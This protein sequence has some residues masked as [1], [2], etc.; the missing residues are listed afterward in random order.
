MFSNLLHDTFN[1]FRSSITVAEEL[2]QQH[3]STLESLVKI[4]NG[5]E[6]TSEIIKAELN[7]LS[8]LKNKT[9]ELKCSPQVWPEYFLSHPVIDQFLIWVVSIIKKQNLT[10]LISWI[11]RIV[12]PIDLTLMKSDR[13]VF[14]EMLYSDTESTDRDVSFSCLSCCSFGGRIFQRATR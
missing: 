4:Q 3:Q 1:V 8:Q 12:N 7:S 11:R 14:Q 9:L 13:K 6:V 10:E 2:L 5:S